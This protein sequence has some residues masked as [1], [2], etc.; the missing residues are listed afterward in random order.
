MRLALLLSLL[1]IGCATGVGDPVS[2]ESESP[3]IYQAPKPPVAADPSTLPPSNPVPNNCF[4]R[5]YWIDNCQVIEVFCDNKLVNIDTKCYP[6]SS[7][8]QWQ[9]IPDPP[10]EGNSQKNGR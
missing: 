5:E 2:T 4:T 6:A 3:P 7:Q 1:L 8:F 9:W 10:P